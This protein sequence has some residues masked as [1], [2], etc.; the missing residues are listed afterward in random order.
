MVTEHVVGRP[1]PLSLDL[2]LLSERVLNILSREELTQTDR[3]MLK[4]VAQFLQEVRRGGKAI[5][6]LELSATSRDIQLFG[7]AMSA[8]NYEREKR[9]ARLVQ[10]KI[11]R[12]LDITNRLIQAEAIA[13]ESAEVQELRDFFQATKNV[14]ARLN[15]GEIDQVRIG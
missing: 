13:L 12:L 2:S 9:R 8:Y 15:A 10:A 6:S 7:F 3:N 5:R 14:T 1:I 11:E 4:K